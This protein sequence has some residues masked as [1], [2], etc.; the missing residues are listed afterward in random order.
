MLGQNG[1]GSGKSA[2][3]SALHQAVN[4]IFLGTLHMPLVESNKTLYS[5]LDHPEVLPLFSLEV[6]IVHVVIYMLSPFI[7]HVVIFSRSPFG[8]Y[9]LLRYVS[10]GK[11]VLLENLPIEWI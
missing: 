9:D 3:G 4:E 10:V 8:S 6:T 1:R 5:S 11:K 2:N 7:D